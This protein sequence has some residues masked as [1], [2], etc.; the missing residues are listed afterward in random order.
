M[1]PNEIP[2]GGGA[3]ARLRRRCGAAGAAVL[4]AVLLLTTLLAACGVQSNSN[5]PK[6]K[7][8]FLYYDPGTY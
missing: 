1:I 4:V 3:I 5:A 2:A 6:E 7:F 8:P